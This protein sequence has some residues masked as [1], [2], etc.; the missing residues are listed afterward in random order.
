MN[1]LLSSST[2]LC[3]SHIL[4]LTS[5]PTSFRLSLP[6]NTNTTQY[7][8]R[9]SLSL[10]IRASNNANEVDT[11]TE[12]ED[13]ATK[14]SNQ[15]SSSSSAAA[16]AID[17]D[18]KKVASIFNWFI[19]IWVSFFMLFRGCWCLCYWY[20]LSQKDVSLCITTTGGSKDCCYLCTKSFHSYKK[21]CCTRN[22]LVYCFWGS[23]LCLHVVR[24]SS[25]FQSHFPI[26]RPWHLEIDGNVVHLDVQ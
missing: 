8:G 7:L 4:K 3:N 26:K 17:K 6:C 14:T 15:V 23:R 5:K 9:D 10:R 1:A 12:K 24:W 13:Q 18:L 20:E 25:F 21:S 11:Q 19:F 2:S 16:S 22:Y